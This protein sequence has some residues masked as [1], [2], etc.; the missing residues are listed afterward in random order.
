MEN[1]NRRL[2]YSLD[3]GTR[4]I[5]GI[6][7]DYDEDGN[8]KVLAHHSLS[9]KERNMYDGQ[10]HNI[11]GVA[12][13]VKDLTKHLEDQLGTRLNYVSIAAAG[14]A[15]RTKNI[16][17]E[18]LIEN[19]KIESFL[20]ETLELEAIQKAQEEI[21]EKEEDQD[22]FS[23]GYS[24]KSYYLDELEMESLEGHRGSRI[25]V[26][27]IAT[28][29]PKTVVEGLYEVISRAGLQV[30]SITL[31][32]IAAINVAIKKELR[33]LNLA[34]VDIGA[35]TSDIAISKDGRISF[36][37]MTQLAG[38]EI[39]EALAKAHLMD[40]NSAEVLKLRLNKGD[41]HE[42]ENILSIKEKKT[43]EEVIDPIIHVLEE[44]A[45]S[46]ARTILE[47]NKT[48]P[49]AVFL[50]GGTSQMPYLG[51]LIAQALGLSKER[52]VIRSLEDI[53]GLIL[54]DLKG[55]ELITPIGIALEGMES[56]FRN[57][58]KLSFNGEDLSIFNTGNIRVS[59]ILVVKSFDPKN[60][61]PVYGKD[62]NYYLNSKKRTIKG[63]EKTLPRILINKE[64]GSIRSKLKSGDEIEVI[65]GQGQDAE[66]I[67]IIKI[68]PKSLDLT[69][70][71]V[72]GKV[73]SKDY[74]VRDGDQ[75]EYEEV[76]D[77]NDLEE[78]LSKQGQ[79]R[80][81]REF[82]GPKEDLKTLSLLVNNESMDISYKK[83]EFL[84]VDIFDYIDFD[85][86]KLRGSLVLRLN[87]LDADYLRPLKD[88][89]RLDIYW[90]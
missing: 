5:I 21:N 61:L 13:L 70:V 22:Y 87:G 27:I 45:E 88:G 26:D 23:I 19:R 17:L 51:E 64:E 79:A 57:F 81:D 85:L 18:K 71:R 82:S 39:T 75:I 6:V 9:H 49:S 68:L 86:S 55:P 4:N 44:I 29:L 78:G 25:G 53:Q 14:R 41:N 60:L 3:I 37:G 46:I 59:D 73:V 35:G 83:D 12:S 10:I 38:D 48:P 69:E 32:P 36:Y 40:F 56:K 80:L 43:T 72:N 20:I 42:V 15:L 66:P 24:V 58:I 65:P 54:G 89:D 52:V 30:E 16:F 63:R 7:G 34:L 8:F 2:S 90:E 77:S 33:L 76:K 28:F 31:E 47:Y 62:I 67:E 1:E 50:I 74:L 11:N 84:F